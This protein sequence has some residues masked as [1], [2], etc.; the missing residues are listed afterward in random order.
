[1]KKIFISSAISGSERIFDFAEYLHAAKK[2][3]EIMGDS[4]VMSEDFSAG[5]YPLIHCFT[6]K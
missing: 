4:P 1:M 6:K 5:S 3:A 2:V